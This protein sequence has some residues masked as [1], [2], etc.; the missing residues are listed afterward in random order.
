MIEVDRP[1]TEAL[2]KAIAEALK[3]HYVSRP[4]GPDRVL[5]ALNALAVMTGVVL[6]ATGCDPEAVEF[7]ST[8][9]AQNIECNRPGN[10][11]C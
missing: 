8:A 7:F 1:A 10:V 3:V 5:E 2:T 11:G 9:V 6:L 4:P